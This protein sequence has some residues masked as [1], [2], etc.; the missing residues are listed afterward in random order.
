[1]IKVDFHIHSSC[2]HDCLA[3][4][5][6]IL[7][8]AKAIGL[9]RVAITDHNTIE[10]ALAAKR[11]APEMVIVGEEI[12]TNCGELLAYF[13]SEC[14]P[15]GLEPMDA[16][17]RLKA[18]G[19]VISVA[20]PFDRLRDGWQLNKLLQILPQVDALEVYNARVLHRRINA[21]AAKLAHQ[22][23]VTGTAGSDAHS[24]AEIGA[25]Y[26]ELPDFQDA[27]GLRKAL[28]QAEVHGRLSGWLVRLASRWAMLVKSVH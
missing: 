6:R 15:P 24:L 20:H 3:T 23:G 19:A 14:I 27:V 2:S 26:L 25:A 8:R 4:P 11:I 17:T 12:L 18:Q 22:K 5:E 1:M 16:V 9:D 7:A 10:G 28:R 21:R 13:V